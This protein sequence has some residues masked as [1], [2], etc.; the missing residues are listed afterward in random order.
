[1]RNTGTYGKVK[2]AFVVLGIALMSA[3][4]GATFAHTHDMTATTLALFASAVG[5]ALFGRRALRWW[6][7]EVMLGL[8]DAYGEPSAEYEETTRARKL[9]PKLVRMIERAE[10]PVAVVVTG[11][12]QPPKDGT[13]DTWGDALRTAARAGAAIHHYLPPGTT[14]E[15]AAIAQ[16]LADEYRQCR[17]SEMIPTRHAAIELYYPTVIAWQRRATSIPT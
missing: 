7:G 15:E 6:W 13:P 11:V 4:G 1:M 5:L 12:E 17:C 14:E 10:G 8:D 9:A 3:V 2:V 16:A